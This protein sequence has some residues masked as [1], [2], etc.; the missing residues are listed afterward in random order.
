MTPDDLRRL[1]DGTHPRPWDVLG[2]HLARVEEVDG[3]LFAVW[4]PS[5]GAVSVAAGDGA[6][7]ADRFPL[8]RQD[9][10]I[11][12][13]FVAGFG[14]GDRYRFAVTGA[15][16]RTTLRADPLARWSELRPETASR[17]VGPTDHR[18]ADEAWMRG[19]AGAD[20]HRSAM[21]IYEV[22]LGS[23]RRRP[24]GGWLSY[25]EIAP[26]LA[27][28]CRGLGFTHVE[29]M[30][31]AEHP[32]DG[33]WGYQV[34]GYYAPTSRFGH[35]DGLRALVD[36]LHRAGIGVILDWVPAHF[37]RDEHALAR[38]DGTALYE[39]ADPMRGEHPDWGT[40]IFD[41][42]RPP[43][44]N[45]LIANALYWLDEFHFDG[46]RVD[47]VASMLY[48]DYSRRPG[49]WRPNVLGGRENLE[50]IAFLQE[51]NDRVHAAVPGAITVAEES[52]AFPG[53]SRPTAEGGLGFDL[54]WD[55]GWM[56]DTLDYFVRAPQWRAAR[57]TRITFRGVYLA[58]ER[59]VLPLSHDEVV[60]L[61][62]SLLGKMPG[63][64]AQRF[65][66]LRS[67][68]AN[69]AGQPGKKLLFMGSELAPVAE[70]NHDVELPWEAAA[71]DPLRTAL[72]RFVAE[73]GELYRA[74][75]ALWESD[76]DP[77]TFAWIDIGDRDG[78]T[79]A[80][81]RRGADTSGVVDLMVVV[82]NLG[83]ATRRRY[84]LGLPA[85]G[86]WRVVLNTES[87][88]FGGASADRRAPF[89]AEGMGTAG[90][91][92]STVITLPA[93]GTLFLRPVAD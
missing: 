16:R 55:L 37:P 54:K 4:A 84:W 27:D 6:R 80:W 87:R 85:P 86:R 65:A 20:P 7:H 36:T 29:L 13:G 41:F 59:W 33:S 5:A 62:R 67:L 31:I 66:S 43:V 73:L 24:D 21:R 23:W 48:L 32:F 38:F 79:Y 3:T 91:P 30:P 34:T 40:L 46:L 75:P 56:H 53:V 50:A 26:L 89:D 11:W 19:R 74:T 58:H 10:G 81:V 51:L 68:L 25:A 9:G 42:A 60:H 72:G 8:Q 83:P 28:H 2:A 82:Q 49:Q 92:A 18:W 63:D 57:R 61:K 39:H 64:E 78:T 17:V 93:L 14:N 12:S 35:P 90:Q 76:E 44:R 69:Q 1:T 88:R 15:D 22:H 70:W 45:F 47:A 52:T 77:S 71:G